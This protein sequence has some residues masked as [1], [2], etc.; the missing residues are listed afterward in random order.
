[1]TRNVNEVI[2]TIMLNYIAI[3]H[4]AF[5][6]RVEL[7]PQRATSSS[8]P[9]RSRCPTSARLPPLNRLFELF[10]FNFAD[11][12]ALHGFLPFAIILGIGYYLLLN[13]SRF[14]FDLRLSAGSTRPPPGP[15]ASTRRRWSSR[16]SSCRAPSPA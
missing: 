15:P 3:G 4:R 6:S 14:G 7:L 12:V 13:R 5:L 11:G 2:S 9:R 8:S 16:R 1:M 10:G